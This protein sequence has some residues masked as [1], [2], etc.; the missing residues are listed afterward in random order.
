MNL[1][2]VV[3]IVV[4]PVVVIIMQLLVMK[5]QR[6]FLAVIAELRTPADMITFKRIAANN[7]Y[8]AL[9]A[10]VLGLLPW[11][12]W[13]VGVATGNLPFTALVLTFIP[14][15]VML[16]IGLQAKELEKRVQT[17]PAADPAMAAERD[18]VV[19]IWLHRPLP[20]W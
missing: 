20:E 10:I 13:I 17:I 18:R 14:S 11:I 12:V 3:G 9:G 2:F 15:L 8:L 1:Y 7:M 4:P 5:A 16:V 19:D 6:E